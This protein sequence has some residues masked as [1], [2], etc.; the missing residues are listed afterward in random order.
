MYY[1]F[2]NQSAWGVKGTLGSGRGEI[3]GGYRSIN[4]IDYSML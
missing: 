4:H 2:A 1:L 3:D